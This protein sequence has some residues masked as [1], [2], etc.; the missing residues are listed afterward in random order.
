MKLSDCTAAFVMPS[1]CTS[2]AA[3]SGTTNVGFFFLFS[4]SARLLLERLLAVARDP[5]PAS[6]HPGRPTFT[7]SSVSRRFTSK[8][9]NL[10][11][12]A[13]GRSPVVAGV[14]HLH[15]AEHLR[16]DDLDVLV[17]D[18]HALR[19]VD[20]LHLADEVLL[21]LVFAARCGGCRA[22]RAGRARAGRRS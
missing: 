6:Y 8:N 15:L 2:N 14:C 10:S 11:I 21:H 17:V 5:E 3:G 13:P 18:V 22:G 7:H 16:D 19:A 20:R 4:S 12:T 1:N 9:A